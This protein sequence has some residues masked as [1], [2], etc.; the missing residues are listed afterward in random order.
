MKIQNLGEKITCCLL[1]YNHKHLI[2]STVETIL[3]QTVKNFEFIISDDCSTDGTWEKILELVKNKKNIKAI[4]T[5]KN[6]KM[7]GNC[8]YAFAHSN[9]EYVAILHHDD[10]FDNH[11]L[12]EWSQKLEKYPKASFVFNAYENFET[13]KITSIFKHDYLNGSWL[14][15]NYLFKNFD[16]QIRG[17]AM[18]RKSSWLE[19]GGMNEKFLHLSDI[20]LWMRL[21]KISNVGYIPKPLISVRHN[22]PVNYPREYKGDIWKNK[23]I[24]YEIHAEN[25]L[26]YKNISKFKK[27]LIWMRFLI[28]LNFENFKW[29]VYAIIKRKKN[30]VYY[31]NDVETNYD[32]YVN[33][34]LRKSLKTLI[35]LFTNIK[36]T[37]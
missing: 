31:S 30:M 6:L 14:L 7:S 27:K 35:K 33:K 11:L 21:S 22:R 37:N 13:K 12:E 28:N 23:K 25:I 18:I 36:N 4:Q 32:F 2:E 9:R 24:V 10:L 20:D 16:C 3:D 19:V 1:T 5:P 26:N 29:L 34:L 15:E 8:N 17:S